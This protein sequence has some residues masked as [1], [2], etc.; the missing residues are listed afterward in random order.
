MVRIEDNG[1]GIPAETLKRIQ[2]GVEVSTSGLGIG[3][4]NVAQ[5]LQILYEK[6]AEFGIESQEGKGTEV[7]L[8]IPPANMAERFE[9]LE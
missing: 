7:T 3:L 8:K 6:K 9:M 2:N 4:Q 1:V 5:R